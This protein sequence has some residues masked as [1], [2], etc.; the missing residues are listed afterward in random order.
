[1]KNKFKGWGS[2]FGFTFKQSVGGVGFKVG[3]A[4]VSI[5]LIVGLIA[6]NLVVANESK[7]KGTKV[8]PIETVYVSD[9]SGL[10]PTS[11]ADFIKSSSPKA[12]GH[13]EFKDAGSGSKNDIILNAASSNNTIAVFIQTKDSGYEMEGI[14]PAESEIKT[15]QVSALLKDMI[16]AFETNKLMQSGIS[17]DQLTMALNPVV[18]TLSDIGE[19]TNEMVYVIKIFAPM[20]FGVILYVMLILYGQIISK[21]VSTEKTS[22]LMET[23]LTSIHPYALISGKILGIASSAILQFSIWIISL[24]A[25]LYG[26]NAITQRLFP[27]YQNSVVSIV[28]F[29]RENIG[30]AALSL[31]G[32]ILAVIFL[33]VGFLFYC[34]IAGLAG[35]LVSKPEEVASTQAIFQLPVIISWLICYLAPLYK[36][37]SIIVIARYVPF[38]SPFSVPVDLITGTIGIGH[39]LIS[40]AVLSAFS[41]IVI[42]LSARIY[43]GMVLYTGQKVTLK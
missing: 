28:N 42:M 21:S 20:L 3:T 9:N 13:I 32:V 10:A 23:L 5:L 38:T 30:E 18:T 17:P 27:E 16:T 6:V 43:K 1:M 11:F 14:I 39:G 15:K 35:C 34:V 33:F 24:I 25:G 7:D 12:F 29:L 8:S 22:K 37:E 41:L 26:G 19:S 4:I 2:V 31:P 40:L 36:K